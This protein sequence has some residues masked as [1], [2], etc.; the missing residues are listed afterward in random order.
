MDYITATWGVSIVFW[1]LGLFFWYVTYIGAPLESK[2]SGKHVS[3][4]PGTAFICF[5]IAGLASPIK[6]LTLVCFADISITLL[7]FYLIR[8]HIKNK[9]N[10]G[11]APY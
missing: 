11:T 2:K 4:V 1:G 3:G 8:E 10:K 6:W 9:K 7:P 5:L